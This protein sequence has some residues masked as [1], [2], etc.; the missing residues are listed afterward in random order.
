MTRKETVTKW[1]ESQL[2][3]GHSIYLFEIADF[4]SGASSFRSAKRLADSLVENGTL[5]V[6]AD[7]DDKSRPRYLA[8]RNFWKAPGK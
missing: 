2:Q 6:D 1:I 8:G 5:A 3:K 4:F 7:Q